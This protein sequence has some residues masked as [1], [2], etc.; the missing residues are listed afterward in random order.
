M[1]KIILV[2]LTVLASINLYSQR[3]IKDL[4]AEAMEKRMVFLAWGEFRPNA[5]RILGIPTNPAYYEAW[6]FR[7]DNRRYRRGPDIRPLKAGGEEQKRMVKLVG[8]ESASD[9][10]KNETEELKNDNLIEISHITEI[11]TDVDPLYTLYYKN[12]LRNLNL[13]NTIFF[14][15]QYYGNIDVQIEEEL[16]ESLMNKHKVL[17]EKYELIK[18]TDMPRGKR[19]LAYHDLMLELRELEKRIYIAINKIEKDKLIQH[20]LDND[21]NIDNNIQ[22]LSDRDR[23]IQMTLDNPIFY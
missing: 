11:T 9:K 3:I 23:F 22:P 15:L 10:S 19:F 1:K 13:S 14:K 16:M 6:V 21:I 2:T 17:H 4:S 7:R 12:T 5:N 8:I 20:Q 18:K